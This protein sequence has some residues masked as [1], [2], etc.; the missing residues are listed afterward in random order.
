[1]H[2]QILADMFHPEAYMDEKT[3]LKRIWEWMIVRFALNTDR[4]WKVWM[5]IIGAAAHLEYLAVAML[6]ENDGKREP[7]EDYLQKLTLSQLATQIETNQLLNPVTVQI[8]RDVAVLRN[9]VAHKG[10]TWG[11]PF[12]K[13]EMGQYKGQHVFTDI[14]GLEMFVDDVDEATNQMAKWRLDHTKS[15]GKP[16]DA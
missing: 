10:A 12:P 16:Q 3:L 15:G 14:G 6:W 5:F 7:F 9:S 1:L 11:I 4:D 13:G 8:V 2:E